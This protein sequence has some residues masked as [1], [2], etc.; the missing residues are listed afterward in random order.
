MD[1]TT[2]K[3]PA[4]GAKGFFT[5]LRVYLLALA[6]L[7]LLVTAPF[8][9]GRG[10]A[11]AGVVLV[12]LYHT[13]VQSTAHAPLTSWFID[14]GLGVAFVSGIVALCANGAWVEKSRANEVI[15]LTALVLVFF[16]L[17]VLFI[18]LPSIDALYAAFGAAGGTP[19]WLN[20]IST[21]LV[22]IFSNAG[23]IAL[24]FAFMAAMLCSFDFVMY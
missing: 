21:G 13:A 6:A 16:C 18:C 15:A 9:V 5:P 7:I 22:V 4:P 19:A 1:S 20:V 14:A 12:Q 3:L 24:F 23:H 8:T 10:V 11:Y 2:E 17:E